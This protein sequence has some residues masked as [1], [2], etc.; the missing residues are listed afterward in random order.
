MSGDMASSSQYWLCVASNENGQLIHGCLVC[1]A[2]PWAILPPELHH[3]EIEVGGTKLHII[4]ALLARDTASEIA[5]KLETKFSLDLSAYSGPTISMTGQRHRMLDGFGK[6]ASPTITYTAGEF[7]D[8]PDATWLNAIEALKS[9]FG[10]DFRK[11]PDRLG[12]FLVFGDV[13]ATE[14]FASVDFE[15]ERDQDADLTVHPNR[16]TLIPRGNID[17]AIT[18]LVELSIDSEPAYS[19]LLTLSGHTSQTVDAV[20]FD[21][22]RVSVFDKTGSLIFREGYPLMLKF[23]LNLS[24]VGQTYSINDNLAASA[25]GV[26]KNLLAKAK[27]VTPRSTTRSFVGVSSVAFDVHLSKAR[28]L[29]R[30]LAPVSTGDRW[31]PRGIASEIEVIQHLNTMLDGGRVSSAVI[32]DPFFGVD[33]LRRVIARL[34]SLDVKLTVVMSLSAIDPETNQAKEGLLADLQKMLEELRH[35][36]THSA[37]TA[38][39]VVNL[40]DGGK[41]A[42]HDRY[43]LLSPHEGEQEVYLLSNSLNRMAGNWP[44]CISKLDPAAARDAAHYIDGLVQGRDISG[45]TKPEVTF[46]WPHHENR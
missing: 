26:G 19:G 46:Q 29:V 32:V 7:P 39:R 13:Q 27:T 36:P 44:F 43:L 17:G 30:R 6:S 21:E 1:H 33:T 14:V 20:P 38:L 11:H 10:E 23:G 22:Y 25:K 31:F 37:I 15:V 4:Q 28:S 34:E 45:S 40:A 42:F 3:S 5:L 35:H 12:A 2:E 8:F 18:V 9:F 24:A 16:F 41:Q